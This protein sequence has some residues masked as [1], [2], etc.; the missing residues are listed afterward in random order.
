MDTAF[1]VSGMQSIPDA[2]LGNPDSLQGS[3]PESLSPSEG[4]PV[5]HTNPST[6]PASGEEYPW[7]MIGLGLDEPLPP[8]EVI[9]EL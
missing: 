3:F 5:L 7:E 6:G 2:F 4:F 8:Q 1:T 9:N